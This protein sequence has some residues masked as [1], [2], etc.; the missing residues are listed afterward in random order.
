MHFAKCSLSRGWLSGLA[1]LL[2][3]SMLAAQADAPPACAKGTLV[4]YKE[5]ECLVGDLHFKFG[6]PTVEAGAA[7]NTTVTPVENG[8]TFEITVPKDSSAVI[9]FVISAQEM[10]P[11][12]VRNFKKGITSAEF[13]GTVVFLPPPKAIGASMEL[14]SPG[15]SSVEVA[16][17]LGAGAFDRFAAELAKPLGTKDFLKVAVK[18]A[19]HRA[20]PETKYPFTAKFLAVGIE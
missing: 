19:V 10:I 20:D 16:M 11:F 6:V 12:E 4:D 2:L 5:K 13:S 18:L 7:K 1:L 9:P 8:F 14:G 3:P 17:R 15:S